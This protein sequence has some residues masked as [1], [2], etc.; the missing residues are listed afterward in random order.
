MGTSGGRMS[1]SYKTGISREAVDDAASLVRCGIALCLCIERVERSGAWK[2]NTLY[3]YKKNCIVYCRTAVVETK[4][5]T[6]F[7]PIRLS[8]YLQLFFMI[9]L[10]FNQ[11]SGLCDGSNM[12]I[13]F[14]E[15][16]RYYIIEIC[17]HF[18]DIL[19]YTIHRR[20]CWSPH[21]KQHS[22]FIISW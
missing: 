3:V 11:I 10:I 8:G 16:V 15:S 4:E 7:L 20:H 17:S 6:F 9:I 2:E 1:P 14:T 18:A 12:H 21:R 19:Q 22:G 5:M 13:H